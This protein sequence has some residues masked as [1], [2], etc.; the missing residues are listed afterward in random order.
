ML[1]GVSCRLMIKHQDRTGIALSVAIG[2]IAY[3][4]APFLPQVNSILI[5]LSLGILLGNVVQLPVRVAPGIKTSSKRFLEWAIIFLGFGINL[6]S[7]QSLGMSTVLIIGLTVLLTI[8][9]T[10]VVARFF[11]DKRCMGHLIGF[12]TAICGSSA[13]AAFAPFVNDK[14]DEDTAIS[15]ATINLLGLVFMLLLPFGLSFFDLTD[16]LK[17]LFVGGGLQAV[18]NVAFAGGVINEDVLAKALTI[19]L[20]RITLLTPALIVMRYLIRPDISWRDSIKMPYYVWFFIAA[21][22]IVTFVPIPEGLATFL[23]HT[24]KILLTIAMVA[25]GL[26]INI[27]N[28]LS[29][30]QKALGFGLVIFFIHLAIIVFLSLVI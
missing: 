24:G 2:L 17:A 5:G 13:I 26:K 9:M 14:N 19:K 8:S 25:I 21:S 27:R 11:G 7:I 28:L 20:G 23:K 6:S 3:L 15:I 10:F 16:D 12:G 1:P 4:T 30:G 18:G 22:V 29:T